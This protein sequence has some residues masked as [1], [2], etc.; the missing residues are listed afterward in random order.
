MAARIIVVG[1]IPCVQEALFLDDFVPGAVNRAKSKHKGFGGKGQLFARAA[2]TIL[3][4]SAEVVQFVGGTSGDFV[5]SSLDEL[6]IPHA[7]IPTAEPTRT[8]TTILSTN[9]SARFPETEL[10]GVPPTI[11]SAETESFFETVQSRVARAQARAVALVGTF[12]ESC[13]VDFYARICKLKREGALIFVDSY[14]GLLPALETGC[15]DVLKIN[16]T[17]FAALAQQQGTS[18][19]AE[20]ARQVITFAT[21]FSITT[22]ALTDGGRPALL[23][24]HSKATQSWEAW[25]L[26]VPAITV[27]NAIGAGDTTA[28]GFLTMILRDPV[29]EAFRW[30]LAA[31]SA[32]C[33]SPTPAAFE[34]ETMQTMYS[35]VT[36]TPL[37]LE[38]AS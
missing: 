17:E 1:A 35:A 25:S 30:G 18:S 21:R 16:K 5:R 32:S 15:I 29:H 37:V 9:P 13:G 12:P 4:G 10:V 3:A 38:P 26:T 36:V 8:C 6:H 31:G 22:V 2:N 33:L 19:P 7:D 14:R 28:A 24:S 34:V 20:T 27:V 23:V 11:T